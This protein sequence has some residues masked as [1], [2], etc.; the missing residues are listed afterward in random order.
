M[1]EFIGLEQ[2]YL[3]LEN[4]P[5]TWYKYWGKD[6]RRDYI[7]LDKVFEETLGQPL[8]ERNK[9]LKIV[10]EDVIGIRNRWRDLADSE[11]NE[12]WALCEKYN[13]PETGLFAQLTT[14]NNALMADLETRFPSLVECI[15]WAE[16][17][18]GPVVQFLPV[19]VLD[20]ND[21]PIVV[22]N[23]DRHRCNHR[24]DLEIKGIRDMRTHVIK[25]ASLLEEQTQILTRALEEN[26]IQIPPEFTAI[27][28][29]MDVFK[30]SG[31]DEPAEVEEDKSPRALQVAMVED[32]TGSAFTAGYVIQEEPKRTPSP[33]PPPPPVE[34]DL[35]EIHELF[36]SMHRFR[37][38]KC[39]KTPVTKEQS[40]KYFDV[41]TKPRDF[42]T[43]KNSFRTVQW[44][45]AEKFFN[46]IRLML[47]NYSYVF[48]EGSDEHKMAERFQ[49]AMFK[50]LD[51]YGEAGQ[52]AKVCDLPADWLY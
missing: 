8:E 3:P 26:G 1:P 33:P 4:K 11:R 10:K 51:E 19:K 21:T 27:Q 45:G 16:E 37:S 12:A 7:M 44:Y 40:S 25:K 42:V 9:L 52:T 5:P 32:H 6:F 36:D 14:E 30:R 24:G 50:K 49:V 34:L 23:N 20:G 18:Y 22:F 39:F 29:Q 43:I 38:S 13:K 15:K 47:D 17:Y 28:S 35:D 46:D 41:V 2:M 31:P 48:G